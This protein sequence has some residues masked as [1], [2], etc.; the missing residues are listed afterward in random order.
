MNRP[1]RVLV[2]AFVAS[3]LAFAS[4]PADDLWF[5]QLAEPPSVTNDELPAAVEHAVALFQSQPAPARPGRL[6]DDRAPRIVF[7]SASDGQRQARTVL[8]SGAG[9]AAAITEAAQ[10]LRTTVD[11]ATAIWFK[12]DVVE[13]VTAEPAVDLDFPL[14]R[15]R[16]TYGLAFLRETQAAFLPEELVANELVDKEGTLLLERVAPYVKR[17]GGDANALRPLYAPVTHP[18]FRFRTSSVFWSAESGAVPL[19]RGH[20]MFDEATPDELLAM[21][22]AGGDYLK[23]NVDDEGHITYHYFPALDEAIADYNIV[24]HAGTLA[25]M[26]E[27]YA[28][29]K[30]PELLAAAER[31]RA[32]LLAQIKPIKVGDTDAACVVYD[33]VTQLGSN[34]LAVIAL[35]RRIDATGDK[36]DLPVLLKMGAWIEGTQQPDGNFGVHKQVYP[37]GPS[38]AFKSIYFPGEAVLALC[39]L[40]AVTG[41]DHWIEAGER[42]ARWI[43]EVRDIDVSEADQ[44][45]DH[46]LL[47]GLR[48]I[49]PRFPRPSYLAH[50]EKICRSILAI[51]HL[52]P[53]QPDWYGGYYDPPRSTPL[54]TRNEA[55][56]CGYAVLRRNGRDELADAVLAGIRRGTPFQRETQYR[57]ESSLHF[58]DPQRIRGAFFGGLYDSSVRN[59]YIQHNIS[60]LLGLRCL[61]NGQ[62]ALREQ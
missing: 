48:D 7:L 33:G 53:K 27:L 43:V 52:D 22:V 41:D 31:A 5:D 32:F 13:K 38:E 37:D 45:H 59:D 58:A 15:E 61:M 50:T 21:A 51:Q 18:L 44:E 62:A 40:T 12:L 17:T 9:I 25:S 34:A 30:D 1:L 49:E 19:Y 8:G 36:S 47:Y 28:V 39:R 24:R 60:A 4:A 11:P 46:W 54:A 14:D 55:L 42:G 56:M 26:Y 20:A 6:A 57:P 29:T 35:S 10:K 16:S 3:S 2:F 23:R